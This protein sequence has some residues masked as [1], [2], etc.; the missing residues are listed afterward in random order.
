MAVAA[1]SVLLIALTGDGTAQGNH[2]S[3]AE[4]GRYLVNAGDC[5]GCHTV[6]AAKPFAGGLGVQTPFGTIY[7][8]NITPDPETGIGHW[9]DD[10]FYAAMHKGVRPDGKLLYPAFPYPWFTKLTV[11]DVRAIKSYL[12]TLTPVRQENKPSKLPWPLSMR[13]MMMGWNT[14]YFHDGAFQV[15]PN[16][17]AQWNR[18][19]Y[20]VEGPGHCGACHTPVNLLGASK[21]DRR[22]DGGYAENWFSP[23]LTADVREGLGAWSVPE[24]V[25]YLKTG[26]T[27]K[28]AAAGPMAEVVKNSTQYLS[29][30]DLAAMAAYLKD[31]AATESGYAARTI[32][33][34]VSSRGEAIYLDNCTGCHL[35]SG[36]GIANVFPPLKASA[37]VQSRDPATVLQA[38]IGGARVVATKGKPTGLAMPAFGWKLNDREIAD[39]ATYIRNSWGN[40]A[41][42]VSVTQVAKAREGVRPP[43]AN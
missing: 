5:A 41:D 13:V 37:V 1:G 30:D 15:A 29:D 33:A 23:S 7:S 38:V 20:L 42:A 8:S 26:S 34:S 3:N 36:T 16:K 19:A 28:A 18:G 24:I 27:A 35:Q 2:Y 25:E 32:D 39:L 11:D 12:N 10:E 21:H 14:L 6:D 4:R 17:S 9:T 40:S 43:A 31:T 22:F